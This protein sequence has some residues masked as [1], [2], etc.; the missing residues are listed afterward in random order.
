MWLQHSWV[1][2]KEA[3]TR[4]EV[5]EGSDLPRFSEYIRTRFEASVE[6]CHPVW[7]CWGLVGSRRYFPA[8]QRQKQLRVRFSSSKWTK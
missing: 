8:E 5:R 3:L 4:L 6:C 7:V 2:S 1:M